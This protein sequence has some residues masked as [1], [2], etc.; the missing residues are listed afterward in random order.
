[1]PASF[2][3][4]PLFSSESNRRFTDMKHRLHRHEKQVSCLPKQTLPTGKADG[5]K[6]NT[7][8]NPSKELK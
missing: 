7:P 1:M 3:L 8:A 6:E 4:H 2:C 5:R